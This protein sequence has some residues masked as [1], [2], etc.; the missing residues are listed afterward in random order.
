MKD[1]KHV[2]YL[3]TGSN[4]QNP[5]VQLKNAIKF[6]KE[7][8]GNITEKSSVYV[9]AAW[10]FTNQPDF[11]N[12]VLKVETFLEP[13]ECMQTILDI[14]V[15]MGRVRTTPNAPRTIDIDIL[16][17]DDLILDKPRLT[18]PHPS[19]SQRKFVLIP[20]KELE[21][22]FIHPVLNKD[23]SELLALCADTLNVSKM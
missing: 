13:E 14:E 15:Q 2:A 22:E 20:M 23:I 4:M 10:G 5:E 18:L 3:L 8:I 21:P 7:R 12:Q 17:Y 1:G 11:L 9:T 6:I 19:I 16:F